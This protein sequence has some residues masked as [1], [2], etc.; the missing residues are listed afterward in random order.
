MLRRTFPIFA[1]AITMASLNAYADD[2]S[3]WKNSPLADG[4][5]WLDSYGQTHEARKGQ[6]VVIL[7][8]LGNPC[9]SNMRATSGDLVCITAQDAAAIQQMNPQVPVPNRAQARDDA[10]QALVQMGAQLLRQGAGPAPAP[11]QQPMYCRMQG[12]GVMRCDPD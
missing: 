12:N 10:D 3:W 4:E 2:D 1:M 11:A 7:S 9:V 6:D 8:R 5:Q